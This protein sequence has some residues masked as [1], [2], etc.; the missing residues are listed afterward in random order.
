VPS[1]ANDLHKL[2]RA[3]EFASACKL[4]MSSLPNSSTA[5]VLVS[6]SPWRVFLRGLDSPSS[7]PCS[8]TICAADFPLTNLQPHKSALPISPTVGMVASTLRPCFGQP[9]EVCTSCTFNTVTVGYPTPWALSFAAIV[10]AICCRIM[11]DHDT[12]I[13]RYKRLQN[14]DHREDKRG[15]VIYRV[16]LIPYHSLK[17]SSSNTTTGR[18]I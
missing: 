13:A 16:F 8:S 9:V 7:S 15:E 12:F 14:Q 5:P 10:T 11:F 17:S 1:R 6:L 3:A 18:K 4:P 2:L